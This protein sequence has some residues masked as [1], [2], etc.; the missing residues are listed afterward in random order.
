MYT[1]TEVVQLINKLE[2]KKFEAVTTERFEYAKKIKS[3][4]S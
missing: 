1:D 4:I 3:A 2:K